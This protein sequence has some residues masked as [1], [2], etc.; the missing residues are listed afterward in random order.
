MITVPPDGDPATWARRLQL[1]RAAQWFA[2]NHGD[3]YALILRAETDDPT[4]YEQQVAAQPLFRS[5]QLDTW[6]TGDAALAREVLTDDRFGWLTRA[7]QRP[8]ERTL[9]LAGTA[10]D[11]GPE[12]RRRLDALAG[13]GGPVLRA[14]AAGARTRVVET[15]AVLLDGIGERFDLAVLARRL[16]AA[17][18]ADLLGVPA[19]R[20]G[21]FAE[22]LA[23]AGRTL[24]SRLCP[25]TVATALA[26]VAATAELTDLLG[27][28]PPP[29]SLSP[30]A[31]GS[32]PPRPSGAGSWPP[33][34]ADDR[35]AAALALAVGT[36]EPAITLLCNAV[37]AL[38]D[39]PGQWALLGGDLDRSAAVVEETLRCFPPVR[40]ESRVAQQDVT[41]GGRFLPADSHLVVLVAMANRGPR[42]AAA[43]NP[44]AFDPGGSR[45]PARDVVGLPQ[46]AGAGP[47]I[48]LVV[49]TALRTLAEA[50]PTLRRASGGVRWRRSPVLLG[51][52]RFPVARAESGEQ[53]SDDRPAL[54]EATRCA[55]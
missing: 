3:P 19:A 48:R 15:T 43:P 10:L 29:P 27:E 6:V 37:G 4:P 34:P 46:L 11:H 38:L 53:R 24:D 40:L 16:V 17:V 47:L 49:T 20:R 14:D 39:R 30:S 23:A 9:P 35:T 7:G 55:S 31:A 12:A 41:L 44:D 33:L 42:A 50:L 8:A 36:A 22:A 5:E 26:T 2:G 51:H 32:G 54:E 1:T 13:F 45:V 28:V 25:Q 21:R 52:A 18:L